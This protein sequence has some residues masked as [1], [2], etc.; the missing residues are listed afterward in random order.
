VQEVL[1]AASLLGVDVVASM[2]QFA[3]G[4]SLLRRDREWQVGAWLSH[5]RGETPMAELAQRAGCSR[6]S[7]ARWLHGTSK[8]RLPD[9]FRLLDALTNRLPQWVAAFVPVAEVPRLKARYDAA[10]AAKHLAFEVPWSEAV[11]RLIETTA[12][13]AERVPRE[14]YLASALGLD[15][16]HIRV[17]VARLLAAGVVEKTRGRLVVRPQGAVDTQ[18]GKEVLHRLKRH[19]SQVAADRLAAPQDNDYFAYNVVSVSAADLE[20][21]RERLRVAFREIR[22]LVAAS[23]PEEVAAVINL[24]VVTFGAR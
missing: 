6:F 12:Y 5:L 21:I 20:R 17:C 18:G 15:I 19:W 24:Q 2:A 8:P 4:T 14:R 9:F 1:R 13:R 10:E 23:Q 3:P 22:S 11:L 7:V 16:E